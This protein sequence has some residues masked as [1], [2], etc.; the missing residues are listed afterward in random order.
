MN[1]REMNYHIRD[2]RIDDVPTLADV[3]VIPNQ[4]AARL[5]SAASSLAL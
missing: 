5:I 4:A 3:V 1:P 2:A